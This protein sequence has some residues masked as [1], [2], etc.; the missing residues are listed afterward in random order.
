MFKQENFGKDNWC[1][2]VLMV[3][4]VWGILKSMWKR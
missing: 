4:S 2:F 3:T 1:K